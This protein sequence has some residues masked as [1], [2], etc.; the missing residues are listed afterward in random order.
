MF[1]VSI[2]NKDKQI[3]NYNNSNLLNFGGDIISEI[4]DFLKFI[5]CKIHT[6]TTCTDDF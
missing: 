4:I 2:L 5:I 6:K 3:K 1:D